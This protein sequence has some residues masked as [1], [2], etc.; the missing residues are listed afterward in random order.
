MK[1]GKR[2][3]ILDKTGDGRVTSED[4]DLVVDDNDDATN[5]IVLSVNGPD[6]L[7]TV[8]CDGA[9]ATIRLNT[10]ASLT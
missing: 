7:I 1:D 5:P 10:P 3:P 6:G 2:V 4:V 8:D 9:S